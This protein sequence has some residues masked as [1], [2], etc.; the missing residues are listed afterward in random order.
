MQAN[1]QT[2]PKLVQT[3]P[4]KRDA[5]PKSKSDELGIL[6]PSK[7]TATPHCAQLDNIVKEATSSHKSPLRSMQPS[8]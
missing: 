1:I 5:E 8:C 6:A 2:D 4:H 7:P 3:D